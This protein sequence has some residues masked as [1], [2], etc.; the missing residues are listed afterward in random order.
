MGKDAAYIRLSDLL[1]QT[2]IVPPHSF[3]QMR[4]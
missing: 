4:S 2:Y 1:A 3:P